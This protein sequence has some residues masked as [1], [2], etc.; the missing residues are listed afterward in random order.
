MRPFLL[1]LTQVLFS[2]LGRSTICSMIVSV[3]A[4]FVFSF[5]RTISVGFLFEIQWRL[6]GSNR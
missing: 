5:Q 1:D 6:T 4:W 3:F 2:L